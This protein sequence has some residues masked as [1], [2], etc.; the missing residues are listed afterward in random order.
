MKVFSK[1]KY[2]EDMH[3]AIEEEKDVDRKELLELS[4]G[5]STLKGQWADESDGKEV[6]DGHIKDELYLISDAW[7][8]EGENN[9]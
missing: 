7:C 3:K 9:E 6:E 5:L 1:E 8:V 4:L 2:I